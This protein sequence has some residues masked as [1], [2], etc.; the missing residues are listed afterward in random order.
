MLRKTPFALGETYHIFNR[1][2]HKQAIFT[3]EADY[4][5]FT[6]LLH[7]ANNSEKVDTREVLRK[8]KG[9]T[10][11]NIF[12]EEKPDK[13]LV[14]VLAYSLMPNHFHLVLREKSEGGITKFLRKVLTGYSMYFN[15]VHGHSGIL[16]QGAFKSSHVGNEPYFRYI[17]SYVHLNCL[18]LF[19]PAWKIKGIKHLTVLKI[20]AS[21]YPYSSFIDYSTTIVR[22]ERSILSLDTAPDFL[23]TQNDLEDLLQWHKDAE[24]AKV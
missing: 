13:S 2:A 3:C 24:F 9:Q 18:D 6:L 10:S 8:Y 12:E 16:S 15:I 23:K 14:D 7:L 4:G 20:A 21:S 1:G 22:P 19:E 5:R 17:F 11:A